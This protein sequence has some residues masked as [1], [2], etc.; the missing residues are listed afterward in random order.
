MVSLVKPHAQDRGE[1]EQKELVRTGGERLRAYGW[2][3][4]RIL[5]NNLYTAF[6]DW[7]SQPRE[8]HRKTRSD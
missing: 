4:I 7:Q 3:N 8:M 2:V 5:S 1:M 6:T